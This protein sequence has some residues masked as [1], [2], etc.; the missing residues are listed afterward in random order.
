MER[1]T[2]KKTAETLKANAEGLQA[3][4]GKPSVIDLEYIKFAETEDKLEQAEKRIESLELENAELRK[5]YK[6]IYGENSRLREALMRQSMEGCEY[7]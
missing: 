6:T 3:A 7:F 2:D 4:G 5:N 1:V